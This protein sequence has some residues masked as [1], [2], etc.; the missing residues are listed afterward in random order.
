MRRF[1]LFSFCL[2]KCI[3]DPF[4]LS[5]WCGYTSKSPAFNTSHSIPHIPPTFTIPNCLS[6]PTNT[7]NKNGERASQTQ[8]CAARLYYQASYSLSHHLFLFFSLFDS[9]FHLFMPPCFHSPIFS[10]SAP[11]ISST[12]TLNFHQSIPDLI[13]APP[14]VTFLSFN[15][16]FPYSIALLKGYSASS[17]SFPLPRHPIISLLLVSPKLKYIP[18]MLLSNNP[19]TNYTNHVHSNTLLIAMCI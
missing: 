15:L 7:Q 9:S 12:A 13:K 8:P 14:T 11:I 1:V 10:F 19:S 4:S 2:E 18:N 3:A 16:H 5:S 6:I 17:L